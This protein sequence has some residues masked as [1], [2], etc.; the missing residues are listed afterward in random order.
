M[1]LTTAGNPCEYKVGGGGTIGPLEVRTH[2]PGAEHSGRGA[3]KRRTRL[4]VPSTVPRFFFHSWSAK[5]CQ[6]ARHDLNLHFD[7][8]PAHHGLYSLKLYD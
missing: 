7:V 3:V 8:Y 4:W 5:H 2:S 6:P 1:L